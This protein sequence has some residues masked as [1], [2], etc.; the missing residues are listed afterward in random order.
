P[1]RPLQIQLLFGDEI[2]L[3]SFGR[4]EF[5]VLQPTR[6]R[7]LPALQNELQ[8]LQA[9]F[10]LNAE[11]QQG[12]CPAPLE[13]WIQAGLD[14]PLD[15]WGRG[16]SSALW[17]AETTTPIFGAPIA[18]L[19]AQRRLEIRRD[20]Q[21]RCTRDSDRR[22][23]SIVGILA[24]LTDYRAFRDARLIDLARPV[25]E[26]WL[27]SR[28][29]P[30]LSADP[31]PLI[32]S[33]SGQALSA[34]P[35]TFGFAKLLEGDNSFDARAYGQQVV[36]L[37]QVLMA[38]RQEQDYLDN[39]RGA[40]FFALLELW[41]AALA[42]DDVDDAKADAILQERIGPAAADAISKATSARD[43]A[44]IANWIASTDAGVA[45]S[46]ATL[47]ACQNAA[48][49]L[50]DGLA[51]M[52]DQFAAEESSAFETLD[53]QPETL[54]TLA[55]LVA[56]QNN[57]EQRYGRLLTYGEFEDLIDDITELRHDLQQEQ[58]EALAQQLGAARTTAALNQ[59]DARYFAAADLRER[60]ERHM[61]RLGEI[62]DGQLAGT[63]PFSD[64]GADDYLNA[65]YNREFTL[66]ARIDA[67]LLT[68]ARPIL[69][70]MAQQINSV[71]Q[72]LGA[73]GAPLRSA[74]AELNNPSAVTAV[75][76][77]YLLDFEDEYEACLGDNAA[78]VTFTEQTNTVTRT[79]SG[80]EISR[81]EGVPVSTTYRI[82]AAHLNLFQQVFT[83]PETP[84][85]DRLFESLLGLEAVGA[86][87]DGVES[88]MDRYACDD[89]AIQG[90]E[91]GLL[92]YY[93]DRRRRWGR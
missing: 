76:L 66:L 1:G 75:A 89:A 68:G 29:E 17:T 41:Q 11:D 54:D 36:A 63:R 86:L 62:Y 81:I 48:E 92:A 7:D 31:P 21:G 10:A 38:R 15:D 19:G 82:K 25:A 49:Q 65:L 46:A 47:E 69:G 39:L 52:A 2:A 50:K 28:A 16:D 43:A 74:A 83:R 60:G 56:A 3:L 34:V 12:E 42:R 78:T 32:S 51:D 77:R 18:S 6:S 71:S 14:L 24:K 26:Q 57:L 44:R 40:R 9:P 73:A 88:M 23:R 85:G 84:G 45:C 72:L 27:S 80:L 13:R 33:K 61:K 37:N 67:Q 87:T 53:A 93:A 4:C 64:T 59:I 20:L 8:L 91:Q 90:F 35:R 79:G 5:G 30:I 55:K 22:R 70:F 58:E